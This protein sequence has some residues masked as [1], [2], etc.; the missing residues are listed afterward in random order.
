MFLDDAKLI[1][2]DEY[3]GTN[4]ELENSNCSDTSNEDEMTADVQS[5]FDDRTGDLDD[6]NAHSGAK[7]ALSNEANTDDPNSPFENLRN[8]RKCHMNNVIIS[9]L[10]VNSLSSKYCEV[11][12]LLNVCRFDVLVL[13]ET[14]LDDS[15]KQATLDIE[16]YSCVRQDKRSNSGGL[17]TYIAK[18]IPFSV[19]KINLCNDD[20]ECTSMELIIADE[21]ILLLGMYKNP[22]I[23]TWII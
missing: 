1:V 9:H 10:N 2:D 12:E 19:G 21:K 18:D 3:N 17:L 6:L 4:V 8:L 5:V 15:F 22:R 11:K 20:I 16:G 23:H 7:G 13:S 14:K